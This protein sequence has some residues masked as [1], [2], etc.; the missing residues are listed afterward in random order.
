MKKHPVQYIFLA[1]LA[2][3]FACE[4]DRT[5]PCDGSLTVAT[6][7]VRAARCGQA[8]GRVTLNASG[9]NGSVSYQLN[10][11]A[12]Q[13]SPTFAAL[14]PG[15]YTIVARD[16]TGCT[17]TLSVIVSDE[18]TPLTVAPA[19]TPSSCNQPTGRLVLEVSG[20]TAPYEYSI[21]SINF[22]DVA[23]FGGLSS[24]DYSVVVRDA[25]GCTTTIRVWVPSEVSFRT[26]VQDIIT[27][28]CAL[29][30]CH[31]APRN[32]NFT[33]K[34]GILANVARIQQRTSERSMPPEGSGRNLTEEEIAQ[35]ACWVADGAP[36]N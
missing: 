12:P 15:N 21:D 25:A 14:T 19:V 18:A 7:A 27:T 13:N 26:T 1:T 9:A 8:D 3:F 28:N 22:T 16:E 29:T 33:T 11:N 36:D 32:P 24:G 31:V 4:G 20:G 30:G 35:I 17:A 5:E 10:D 2:L 23:T 34:E 6:E